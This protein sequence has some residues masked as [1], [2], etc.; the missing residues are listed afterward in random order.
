VLGQD[1]LAGWHYGE[2]QMPNHEMPAERYR[3][4]A[5]ECLDVANNFPRDEHRDALLQMA[6]VWQRL[7]DQYEDATPHLSPS[8]VGREQP[9][10][11]Q[12][13]QVQ[14]KDENDS[15]SA[16]TITNSGPSTSRHARVLGFTAGLL[17]AFAWE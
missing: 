13:Q 1:G 12:Q 8:G 3:R 17:P 6:H 15:P 4:L 7:A 10:M 14:P 16:W 11:Q 5:A 2:A 9:V